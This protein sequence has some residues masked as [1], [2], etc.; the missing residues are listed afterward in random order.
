MD[1]TAV[2]TGILNIDKPPHLTSH[3]VVNHIR[4]LSGIRRVGHAGTLDPLATGVLLL[5]LGPA[6]RFI[7]YLVG[8]QKRY[9]ATVRLGQETTTYD[10]EGPVVAERPVNLTV[11]EIEAALTHFQGKIS[12]LPP[13]YS[14]VKKQGQPLY[15][16][17]RQGVE[18]ERPSRQVTIDNIEI[19]QWQPPALYLDIS[20]SAGTYIRSIAHDLGQLLGCGGHISALRRTAVGDFDLATAVPLAELTTATLS[21]QLLP[22]DTAV[23]H[24]PRLDLTE[25]EAIRLHQGQSVARQLGQPVAPLV[26]VYTDQNGFIGIA[27]AHLAN[28]QA[29]K[30]LPHQ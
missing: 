23:K 17:A 1:T 6:T 27:R 8:H 25:A 13:M 21:Q 28:W 26:R 19:L 15:K 7:E 9:L 14:A 11:A 10:S 22:Q 3:D 2:P 20:C 4:R 18:T 12:Q 16:L 5:C 30:M 24:L 29:H